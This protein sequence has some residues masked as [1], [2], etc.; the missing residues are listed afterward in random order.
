MILSIP[1]RVEAAI[2]RVPNPA[3]DDYGSIAGHSVI[4]IRRVTGHQKPLAA[5]PACKRRW[6]EVDRLAG[7][8]DALRE[9]LIGHLD[10]LRGGPGEP[11]QH[12]DA[13]A[14]GGAPSRSATVLDRYAVH[15]LLTHEP[16]AGA[17]VVAVHDCSFYELFGRIEYDTAFGAAVTDHRHIRAG[18]VHE[19]AGGY[20]LL[21]ADDVLAKPFVWGRLKELLRTGRARIENPGAQYMLFPS[22]SLDP[23]PIDVQ[24]TVVLVGSGALYRL[25]C[26][27]DDDVRRLF[28]LRADFDAVTNW[29]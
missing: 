10:V 7:W 20:L 17:P 24:V 4:R 27:L 3:A 29:G 6:Q 22:A 11:A 1:E 8:L 23:E 16:G 9:D 2:R 12:P 18:A 28:K 13:V 25:L 15:V 26:A 21:R 5:R 14:T 19:A